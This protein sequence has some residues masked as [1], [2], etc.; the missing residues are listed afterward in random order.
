MMEA[1]LCS[2][3]ASGYE[4]D[5]VAWS[6][7]QAALI[8]A[9]RWAEVDVENVAEEIESLGKADRRAVRSHL[10][11]IL[12]NL[13]NRGPLPEY[14]LTNQQYTIRESRYEIDMLLEDSPSLR[15]ILPQSIEEAYGRAYDLVVLDHGR[16]SA[17]T[18]KTCPWTIE[19]ILDASFLP[20]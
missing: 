5:F 7:A 19:Q 2:P 4:T 10:V 14:R 16:D 9:G 18:P 8:R 15:D 6:A 11:N 13:L 3:P 12:V 1:E 17:G 20:E